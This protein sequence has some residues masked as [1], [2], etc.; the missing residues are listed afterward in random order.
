MHVLKESRI[1]D[2]QVDTKKN[3]YQK[4]KQAGMSNYGEYRAAGHTQMMSVE[5]RNKLT[6]SSYVLRG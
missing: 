3:K 2:L 5:V 1:L 6:E 4:N